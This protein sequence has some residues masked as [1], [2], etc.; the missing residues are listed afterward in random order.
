LITPGVS[1]PAFIRL[2]VEFL[3][4]ESQIAH[5]TTAENHGALLSLSGR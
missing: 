3:A 4:I 1:V 5:E 2:C